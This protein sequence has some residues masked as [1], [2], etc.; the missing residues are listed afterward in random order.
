[1]AAERIERIRHV[2][3]LWVMKSEPPCERGEIRNRGSL[4]RYG[5]GLKSRTRRRVRLGYLPSVRSASTVWPG[6]S[7]RRRH[8]PTAASARCATC[9]SPSP[10]AATSAAPT[11]CPRRSSATATS[12]CPSRR[13]LSFE[14]IERLTRIFLGLGV[15]KMRITGGEPL[16]RRAAPG[17][18]ATARV[19]RRA[20][21]DLALTTNGFLLADL[22]EPLAKPA[23]DRVT[24]SLDSLD[25]A[26]F[27][28]HER[29]RAAARARARGDRSGRARGA[30]ADQAQ[31][32]GPARRERGH[33][34]RR[35]C[36]ASAAPVTWSA[37]S[38]SW[39]WG[40]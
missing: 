14:E 29:P 38:S 1:M 12:S 6:L 30:L 23:C 7:W 17:S 15:R 37:S 11:A 21:E 2:V 3:R 13:V 39:T 5:V 35:S 28:Q 20:R 40:R 33:A 10:I 31:L 22:A 16:V 19:A 4:S 8:P 32:R 27:A 24:V 25:E 9:A 26:V 34:G 36:V 18:G